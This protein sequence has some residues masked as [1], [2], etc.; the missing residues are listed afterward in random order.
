[1][2]HQCCK[3]WWV[4][5]QS[6]LSSER[7]ITVGVPQGSILGP[8]L[9]SIY[10]ND[11]PNA[12]ISSDINMFADDTDFHYCHSNLSTVECALQTDLKNIS[13][14]LMV[15]R[16]KLNVSK[17]HCMLIGSCQKTWGKCLHLILNG[18]VLR[19]LSSTK[20]VSWCSYRSAP[21]LE[22]SYWLC[23]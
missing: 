6:N 9:F 21:Y 5:L 10:V 16:L 4:V 14:W 18:N 2:H 17:S 8:L 15:N 11:L 19:Q 23:T 22:Y 13:V 1:M 20:Y 12:N 3:H 7:P